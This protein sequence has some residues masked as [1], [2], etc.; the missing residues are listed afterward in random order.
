M[1]N[2]NLLIVGSGNAESLEQSYG[3]A[4]MALGVK[5]SFWNPDSSLRK[6]VKFGVFGKL[7]S[8]FVTVEPW[9]RKANVDF[10]NLVESLKPE[11][12]LVIATSGLLAGTLA[13][14][15]VL[16]PNSIIYC[17]FPDS[18][19]SLNLERTVSLPLFDRVSC[20]SPAW[21]RTFE[22][23][24]A[25]RVHYL[26]FAADTLFH[27]PIDAE[28]RFDIGFIGTWRPEREELLESLSEFEMQIWGS[29][30]WKTRTKS[31]SILRKCWSG[32]PAI[33]EEFAKVCANSRIMLNILDPITW[34]GP[35]M[36]SF[37]QAACRAFSLS[38]RSQ[39]V[40]EIF[41]EGKTIEYFSSLEEARSKVVYYLQNEDK[42]A[43]IA[44]AGFQLVVEGG[45]NYINRAETIVEW[46][47]QDCLV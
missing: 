30:Y 10:L 6:V 27:K 41:E 4:F 22:Q 1:I 14:A 33:G 11:L 3:R 24:G 35:N 21:I 19:H 47:Q 17:I 28:L 12:I 40:L 31:Q 29:A 26:P 45:H 42:R 16:S 32:R 9:L 36:R 20:S 44:E 37:E 43:Q 25:K 46:Y 18:P 8:S 34:P 7:F 39:A 23:F 15:K 2:L 13:Q 38:F 5:V